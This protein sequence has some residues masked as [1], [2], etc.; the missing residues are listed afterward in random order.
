MQDAILK[1]VR[2]LPSK[3]ENMSVK[4]YGNAIRKISHKKMLSGKDY[5]NTRK[6]VTKN[7]VRERSWK[8]ARKKTIEKCV[9]LIVKKKKKI[10]SEK[11]RRKWLEKDHGNERKRSLKMSSQKERRKGPYC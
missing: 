4:N 5:N 10:V 11:D 9:K 7:D 1:Q 8:T 3:I 2:I 6:N